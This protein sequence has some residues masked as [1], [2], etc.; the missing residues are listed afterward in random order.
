MNAIDSATAACDHERMPASD[1]DAIV[2]GLGGMGSAACYHLARRGACVLGIEQFDIPH[3]LGSSHG[4]SRVIRLAY[5]EDPCYVPL[6]RRAYELW[7]DLEQTAGER[8][9]VTTGGVDMGPPECEGIVG[10]RVAVAEHQIPHEVL[11]AA[12]VRSRFPALN[13]PDGHVAIFQAETGFLLP[14]RCVVAH[15]EAALA[16]GADCRARERVLEWRMIG[17]SP[18]D[19]RVRVTTD[20]GEYAARRLVITA[21]PWLPKLCAELGAHLTIERQVQAWFRP[22]QPEACEVGVMPVFIHHLDD[23]AYYGIPHFG[24]PGVKVC[25]HHGGA[26]VDLETLDR[27][28]TRADEADLRGYIRRCLPVVDGPVMGMKVCLYTNTPDGHFIID[29]HPRHPEAVLIAGG[30]S[31]HGFKFASVVGEVLADLALDGCTRHA[32]E[33]FRIARPR[34]QG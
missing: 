17:S 9:L 24:R 11:T 34:L 7:R 30:F 8:L 4:A 5:F 15:V 22:M 6:V 3:E 26:T 25:R 18:A 2:I 20:R 16:A 21:G 14:E 12:E 13:P 19:S 28:P 1:F 33:P 32:I 10:V 23:A 31:G 29:R 27:V